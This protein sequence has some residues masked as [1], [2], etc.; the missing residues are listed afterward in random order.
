MGRVRNPNFQ[1]VAMCHIKSNE[2]T[3][4]KTEIV[5]QH[6]TPR[7]CLGCVCMH[8]CSWWE[9]VGICDGAQSNLLKLLFV[10]QFM[11]GTIKSIL[12]Y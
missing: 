12:V 3:N 8:L 9:S 10:K 4:L 7:A 6:A 11:R 1:N 2:L 5:P